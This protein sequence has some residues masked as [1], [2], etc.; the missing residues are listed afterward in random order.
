LSLDDA[1][2]FTDPILGDLA[3]AVLSSRYREIAGFANV[4]WHIT[5]RFD[6]TA[7]GRLSRN[8]QEAVQSSA[9]QPVLVGAGGTLPAI[10]SKESVFT[11]SVSPRFELNDTTAIYARVA[12]GYRPGGPNVVPPT[13]GA[14]VPRSYD[15]DTITSYEAGLKTDIT[16]MLSLDLAV[17]HLKW[18]DIQLFTVID[19]FGLNANGGKARSNGFEGTLNLRP[20]RGLNFNL[21]A[22]LI[23]AK[24]SAD[25]P[26]F[27]GGFDGDRLPWVPRTTFSAG[28]DY[29]WNAGRGVRPFV[30]AT[31]AHIGRQRGDFIAGEPVIDPST[32]GQAVDP[33]TGDPLFTFTDQRRVPSYTTLDLR[34]G[35]EFGRFTLQAFARNVTNTRGITSFGE[36]TDEVTGVSPLPNGAVRASIL[37]PRT[38]GFTLGAEF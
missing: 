23:D 36:L 18:N 14:N 9:G 31:V 26:P 35:A 37:Q 25:T 22:A 7:G 21:N 20:M 12:K 19:N 11:Y 17:Y 10:K 8:K 15:A 24:L 28:V 2:E 32:G 16:R 33:V 13:A 30:G 4:T 5:D 1:Q 29:E 34:A 3:T 6:L 38:S 27:V